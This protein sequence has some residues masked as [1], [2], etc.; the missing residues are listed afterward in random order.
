[1]L[2]VTFSDAT[3]SASNGTLRATVRRLSWD[4]QRSPLR[5]ALLKS[6]LPLR[7]VLSKTAAEASEPTEP[8]SIHVP[9]PRFFA[10][11]TVYA[12]STLPVYCNELPTM[13]FTV[14]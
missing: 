14:F 1:M 10:A 11:L 5:R 12:S 7:R 13:G 2:H 3:I 8:P 4:F 9:S 6:P